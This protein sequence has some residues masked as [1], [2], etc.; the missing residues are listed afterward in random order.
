MQRRHHFLRRGDPSPADWD[1]LLISSSTPYRDRHSLRQPSQNE[2]PQGK[3]SGSLDSSRHIP[4][5]RSVTTA[6]SPC[7]FSAMVPFPAWRSCCQLLRPPNACD[8]CV[9]RAFLS[10]SVQFQCLPLQPAP[11]AAN[12][13]PL[14]SQPV[15]VPPPFASSRL[16]LPLP[17]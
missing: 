9:L 13:S 12:A 11:I 16:P 2:W 5:V 15:P 1:F 6:A 10:P 7:T 17:L 8:T 4:H 3:S 14:A